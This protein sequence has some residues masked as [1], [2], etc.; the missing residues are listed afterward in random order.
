MADVAACRA[1]VA[2]VVACRADVADVGPFVDASCTNSLNGINH[3]IMTIRT[4]HGYKLLAAIL[5]SVLY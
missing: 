4:I 3:I 1:D 2:D 5:T